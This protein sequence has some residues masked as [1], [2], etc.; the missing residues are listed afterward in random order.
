MSTR[1]WQPCPT[2]IDDE[3]GMQ[4]RLREV[5][6]EL[7]QRYFADDL[8]LNHA[9]SIET[10]FY[11]RSEEWGVCLLLTPWMLARLFLT[12]TAPEIELPPGWGAEERAAEERAHGDYLVIGPAVTF[13]LFETPLKAHLNYHPRLGHYLVQPLIQG[14]QNFASADEAFAAWKEVI[15]RRDRHILE[16]N[17]NCPWQ[18]EVSRREFFTSLTQRTGTEP[19]RR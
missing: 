15:A 14:M 8:L 9:L 5:Y 10:R 12:N 18:K 1:T 13:P 11:R 2:S 19:H 7:Y 16:R 3:T 6:L 4:E 17:A